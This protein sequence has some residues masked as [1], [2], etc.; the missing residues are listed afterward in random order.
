MNINYKEFFQSK[1]FRGILCGFGLAAVLFLVLGVGMRIGERRAEFSD[2]WGGDFRRTFGPSRMNGMMGK[3]MGERYTEAHGVAGKIIKITLPTVVIEGA[4]KVEK[5]ILL[6][7]DTIIRQF[8]N[9]V[10][11]ADLKVDDSVVVIGS[12][13]ENSQVEAKLIR[14]LPLQPQ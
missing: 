12:P 7:D 9:D 13:N 8:R 1:T 6:K 2:R 10:Q 5:V 14:V 11:P 3:M 4:D